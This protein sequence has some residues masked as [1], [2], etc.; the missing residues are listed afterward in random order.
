MH[1]PY[2]GLA[3]MLL[4]GKFTMGTWNHLFCRK[5]SVLTG[6]VT[7]QRP[8]LHFSFFC[9]VPV[10]QY[11]ALRYV[12]FCGLLFVLF[13]L[14]I[15]LCVLHL[16]RAS[17]YPFGIFRLPLWYLL[18]TPLVSSDYP[19]GV[20]WL[21]LWYRLITPLISSDCIFGIFWLPLWYLLITPLVSSKLFLR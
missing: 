8:W 13:L 1:T 9:G 14:A 21:P 11:L 19:F 17:D 10:A 18:I 4:Y 16:F 5:V 3:G 15:V 12:V 2:A 20:F 7:I 6:L